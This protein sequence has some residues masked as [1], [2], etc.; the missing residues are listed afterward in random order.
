MKRSTP[1]AVNITAPSPI[2]IVLSEQN[3]SGESGT[4][5]ISEADGKITIRV[6]LSGA[7]AD[8]TQPAHIHLGSCADLGAVKYPLVF[9]VDGASTTTLEVSL[10]QLL[11][12]L[13][14]AINVHKSG[15]EAGVYVSC[16]DIP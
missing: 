11:S 8:V 12:A 2:T 10:S 7:P 1:A 15:S 5:T 13:P 14:L 9:S 6:D 3:D 4:S 16:G